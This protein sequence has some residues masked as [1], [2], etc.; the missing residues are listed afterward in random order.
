MEVTKH[1]APKHIQ[2]IGCKSWHKWYIENIK[3]VFRFPLLSAICLKKGFDSTKNIVPI[4]VSNVIGIYCAVKYIFISP[5]HFPLHSDNVEIIGT[6]IVNNY[7]L[8]PD[9]EAWLTPLNHDHRLFLSTI[10]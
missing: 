6:V 1:L 9:T 4:F 2:L 5:T 3:C 10:E 8:G 7:G